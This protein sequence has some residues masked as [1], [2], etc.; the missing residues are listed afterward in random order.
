MKRPLTLL[1]FCLVS[2]FGLH[3]AVPNDTSTR[4]VTGFVTDRKGEPLIGATVQFKNDLQKGTT[5]NIDGLFIL[6]DVPATCL[7]RVSSFYASKKPSSLKNFFSG[8]R[9]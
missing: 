5:T 3:A 2:V 6:S 8:T 1:V 9:A 4:T 7:L